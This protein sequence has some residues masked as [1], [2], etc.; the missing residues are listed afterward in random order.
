MRFRLLWAIILGLVLLSCG[1]PWRA[2]YL[3]EARGH[4]TQK[5][6]AQR[7]GQPNQTRVLQ[8]GTSEWRYEC[9]VA[10]YVGQPDKPICVEYL[11]VF[12]QQE[13]LRKWVQMRCEP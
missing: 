5:D 7:L 11:L 1:G 8:D 2:E 12:D 13:I 10:C 6:I 3:R 9:H 4:A